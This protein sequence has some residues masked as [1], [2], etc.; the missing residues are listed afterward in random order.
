MLLQMPVDGLVNILS[1]TKLY[2]TDFIFPILSLLLIETKAEVPYECLSS[3]WCYLNFQHTSHAPGLLSRTKHLY[4]SARNVSS[5]A[6]KR[7]PRLHPV[8]SDLFM[9]SAKKLQNITF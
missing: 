4:I 3:G 7:M 6:R 9:L 5:R 1:F 2:S 8:C